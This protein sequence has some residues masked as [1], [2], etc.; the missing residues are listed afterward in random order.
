M[1]S[2]KMIESFLDCKYKSFLLQ[3]GQC[4]VKK[5]F[6]N[7]T[8]DIKKNITQNIQKRLIEVYGE[9]NVLKEF[10]FGSVVNGKYQKLAIPLLINDER[11]SLVIDGL[12]VHFGKKAI[13]NGKYIPLLFSEKEKISKKEKLFLTIQSIFLA[14]ITG[15]NF[16]SARI[17]YGKEMKTLKFNIER[18]IPE[19]LRVISDIEK[20]LRGEFEPAIYKK[21]HCK[22]CE[23]EE[24]CR[25]KLIERDDLSLL[26]S[27]RE[28]DLAQY[29]KK[30]IFTVKQLSYT[31]KPRKRN[32]RVKSVGH[33]I[34]ESLQALAIREQKVYL[35]DELCL[36]IA[37][38][39]VFMD[40]EGNIDGSQ[41]YLIGLLIK[42]ND[43]ENMVSLWADKPEDEAHIFEQF[44]KI[45]T[46]LEGP[47]LFYFGKYDY[48]V[49]KR[50]LKNYNNQKI[51]SIVKR[52]SN[53]YKEIRTKL[54]FP[55]Y[56]YGLKEIG[57]FLGC[58]WSAK[59]STGIQSM[60]WRWEW[61][62]ENDLN[63][64]QT[65]INYN[66][67]DCVA[68]KV[69]VDF[70]YSIINKDIVHNSQ[71]I[72]KIS[73]VWE[74]R[75]KESRPNF[76]KMKFVSKDIEI[77]TKCGYFEYQRNRIFFRTNKNIRRVV[78][79]KLKKFASKYKPNSIIN[80]K[81]NKCSKCGETDFTV[82]ANNYYKKMCLDL[83]F[84]NYGIKRWVTLYCSPSYFCNYCTKAF[85]PVRFN[86][87]NMY[88]KRNETPKDFTLQRGYGHNL[89][90]WTVQQY[91]VN[92]VS[93]ENIAKMIS[94]C[95]ELQIDPAQCWRFK[96]E[97]AIYY[98]GTYNNILN[99]IICGKLIH[100]DETSIRLQKDKGYVWVLTNME[101][102]YYIYR[103]TRESD[104]LHKLIKDFWGI[105]IS[106]FYTGYDSLKCL[107][108][109]CL[110][111]L[112]RDL[113]NSLLEN[114]FDDELKELVLAMGTLTRKIIDTI[115]K[116]G[117]KCRYLR[118][119]KQ[120]VK[121]FYQHLAKQ[122]YNSEIAN[123]YKNRL[124]KYE[125]EI[126][127]FLEHD[128]VPWNNNNAEHAIKHF[129]HYRKMV[130]GQITLSGLEPYLVLLSI[131]QTCKYKGISFLDFLLSKE[132]DIDKFQASSK[133]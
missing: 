92:R 60:V 48:Y 113:N 41:I 45:L 132:K 74:L 2:N 53:I 20:I 62:K 8:V 3:K 114:P 58:S 83:R 100:A 76:C 51:K 111:H 33:P 127:L 46:E 35:Y 61:E 98:K 79:D 57:N 5:D 13:K 1:I 110:L 125:K 24:N 17:Y 80:L 56:S 90:A 9:Q 64:K 75:S 103:P 69:L 84:F 122:E 47:H 89:V 87:V 49:L 118:K 95:F 126:F 91:V 71:H 26:S 29:E 121:K 102:V 4:G 63:I 37:K 16:I 21:D 128:G 85:L 65:L 94:D 59:N 18:F 14:K 39:K 32:E 131:Y 116:R 81:A 77:I 106:D 88:L 123:K 43:N 120:E 52:A 6:E 27:I 96:E 15:F 31:F 105:L 109:K 129:A 28:K 11:Y 78:K 133:R 30:G 7:M 22:I 68:L 42:N 25:A 112:I 117:L 82:N 50:I 67:E 23:F 97:A 38:T 119:H 66:Y 107:Q 124:V 99:K 10:K 36:P 19:S 73:S 44:I 108:Q 12:E 40:I 130:G 55:T 70:I 54:Y 86:K 34:Y 104:F 72:P 101:E 115:D 93:L